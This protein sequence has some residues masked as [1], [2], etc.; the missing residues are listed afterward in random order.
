MLHNSFIN[1]F[2]PSIVQRTFIRGGLSGFKCLL[3]Q[4]DRQTW[5]KTT[6]SKATKGHTG[7]W[8]RRRR[9]AGGRWG[10]TWQIKIA[11]SKARVYERLDTYLSKIIP[12]TNEIGISNSPENP[13]IYYIVLFIWQYLSNQGFSYVNMCEVLLCQYILYGVKQCLVFSKILTVS[14]V[15]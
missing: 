13:F 4:K 2:A 11:R 12:L 8:C 15:W 9:G 7:A 3:G 1:I 14:V 6:T 10:Q 5:Y